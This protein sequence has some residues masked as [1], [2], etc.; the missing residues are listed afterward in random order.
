[1]IKLFLND[2]QVDWSE[3]FSILMTYQTEDLNNP[4]IVKN[5]YSKTISIPGTKKNNSIFGNYYQLDRYVISHSGNTTIGVEY[6]P[7]KRIPFKIYNDA[8]LIESGYA[9]LDSISLNENEITYNITLY[10]G[11]GDFFYELAYKET[12]EKLTLADLTYKPDAGLA[13]KGK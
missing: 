6:D 4:T 5:A 11:L 7:S 3:D 9:Q 12:G 2:I 10:G 13:F 1:M 8:N